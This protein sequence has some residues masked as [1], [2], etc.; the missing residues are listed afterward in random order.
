MENDKKVLQDINSLV[1]SAFVVNEGVEDMEM[2]I[3]KMADELDDELGNVPRA[4]IVRALTNMVKQGDNL[5]DLEGVKQEL[6][7]MH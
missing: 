6:R 7:Q 3:E 1:N 4:T 2:K 5:D